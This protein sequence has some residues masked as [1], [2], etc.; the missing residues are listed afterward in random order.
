MIDWFQVGYDEIMEGKKPDSLPNNKD[1]IGE[2]WK[3]Q[4]LAE[5]DY[6]I[7]RC[8]REQKIHEGW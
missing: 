2:Y 6:D 8:L 3:G 1:D 4:V 5:M 7:I